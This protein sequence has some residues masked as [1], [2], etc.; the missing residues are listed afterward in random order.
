MASCA[1][2]QV[3]GYPALWYG[4]HSA[5]MST[6]S[7]MA[8]GISIVASILQGIG[9]LG[10]GIIV[11]SGTSVRGLTTAAS[12]CS[13]AVIEI[14]V[15]VALMAPAIGLTALLALCMGMVP[16]IESHLPA[17]M[18]MWATVR[19][20]EGQRPSEESVMAYFK[21]RQLRLIP[22]SFSVTFDGKAFELRF[23]VLGDPSSRGRSISHVAQD[24]ARIPEVSSFSLEETSRA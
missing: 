18:P 12:I 7:A 11:K 17:R 6:T 16:A 10:A 24:L 3:A 19:Y 14:L 15:G 5:D 9:F 4:A 1:L 22:H 21:E 20:A 13:S 2:L 8:G 23:A